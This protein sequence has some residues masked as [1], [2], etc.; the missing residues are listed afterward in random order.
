MIHSY[1]FAVDKIKDVGVVAEVRDSIARIKGFKKGNLGEAV[2]FENGIHGQILTILPDDLTEV[3]VF[4]REPMKIGTRVA[5]TGEPVSVSVGDGILTHVVNPLG[6]VI[7]ERKEESKASDLRDIDIKPLGIWSRAKIK[8]FLSTGVAVVDLMVPLGEGQREL[9]IGDRKSGKSFFL[10]QTAI[11]AARSG[12]ICVLGLI[13]KRKAEIRATEKILEEEGVI[14][15]CVIVASTSDAPSGEIFLTPYTAMTVAEHFRDK[16]KNVLVILDDMTTHAKYYRELSLLAGRFPGRESYPG[17]VFHIQSAI[18][19]R[20]G[21]FLVGGDEVSIT[22]LPVAESIDADLTGYIQTNLMSMT[23]G[24]IFFDSNLFA[25][26]IR[27]A[28]N[29]FLSVTRVGHQTQPPELKTL[30]AEI[31]NI[32]KKKE[33]LERFHKY[34]PE[35]TDEVKNMVEKGENILNF[36]KQSKFGGIAKEKITS[37]IKLILAGKKVTLEDANT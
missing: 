32:L 33:E 10:L 20:A 35:I 16:K 26:G 4:G 6:Y 15:N 7:D 29:I 11:S 2:T 18:V 13:G 9:V 24:H 30:R 27:P 1:R 23:D 17:D 36:F 12:K 3:L 19:E 21:N 5:R 31:L 37:Q 22:L 34:G 28:V 8:K 14:N 25:K